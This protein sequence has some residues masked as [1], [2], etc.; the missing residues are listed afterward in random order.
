M[1][2]I[3]RHFSGFSLIELTIVLFIVGLLL[4]SFLLPLSTRIEQNKRIT[5]RDQLDEIEQVLYGYILKENRFPCPDCVNNGGNCDT[6]AANDGLEDRLANTDGDCAVEVGNLPWATLGVKGT[7]DWNNRFTYRVTDNFADIAD[8][9]GVGCQSNSPVTVGVSFTLCSNGN[10]RVK[11]DTANTNYIAINIPAIVV[12]HGRNFN[13]IDAAVR[14]PNERENTDSDDGIFVD[15]EYSQ[16]A[17]A[18]FDDML[19]WVSPFLLRSK[20]IKAGILP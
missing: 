9:S 20:M 6:A 11:A 1:T 14:S 18:E 16:Q 10:I 8:G 13:L 12:S 15:A 3:R 19:V 4:S 2:K 5:T 17:G 7:D